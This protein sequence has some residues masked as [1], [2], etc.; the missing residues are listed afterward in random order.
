MADG[1]VAAVDTDDPIE[2]EIETY[3][4]LAAPRSF[5]LYAGAGSGKTRSLVGAVRHIIANYSRDL[6]LRGQSVAVI[7]YTNAAAEEVSRRLEF[8]RLVHVSTIHSFAWTLIKDF[9]SDIREQLRARLVDKIR[10][11]EEK[12]SRPGTKAEATRLHNIER[13]QTRLDSLETISRF[14]YN[15]SGDNRDR[16]SLDHAEVIALTVQMLDTYPRLTDVLTARHPFLFVDESQ[17]TNAALLDALLKVQK[18]KSSLF[19]LGLFGDTMQRIYNDGKVA[20]DEALGDDWIKPVKKMNHRSAQRIVQLANSIRAD[21][22]ANVQLARSDR[23]EGLIRLFLADSS[24]SV[25]AVESYVTKQ[26]SSVTEDGSWLLP[27]DDLSGAKDGVKKLILEHHMA[28][29]R[30]GFSDLFAALSGLEADRT[31]VLEG[32]HP[33]VNVFTSDLVPLIRAS[34]DSDDYT[35]MSVLRTSSPLLSTEALNQN[36]LDGETTASQL[37]RINLAVETLKKLW[38]NDG[39]SPTLFEVAATVQNTGL[40]RLPDAVTRAVSF[41]KENGESAS[42]ESQAWVQLLQCSF[43]ELENYALYTAGQTDFATHQGVKGLEFPR[44]MVVISDDESK[45]FMF[46][47]EKLFGAK[48]PT[49]SDRRNEAEGKET[50]IERTRRLLYVTCTRAEQSLA[51]VAYT[52]APETVR[53]YVS[54]KEWFL[55]NEI[56]VISPADL[57]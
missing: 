41:L 52:M 48:T 39:I 28:A 37:E 47:Y 1:L 21:V 18:A 7:T 10:G 14:T 2:H 3:L 6:A 46:S 33:E 42:D 8:N 15:P 43:A 24:M 40:F 16:D 9:Q 50:S 49:D 36:S 44:V 32:R 29:K 45:G 56:K 26:M 53:D 38:E 4:D 34:R 13:A 54:Q 22:D 27:F 5:F 23:A 30:L 31:A 55:P 12:S 19:C 25:E 20:L 35:L 57:V 51:V 11:W 17:D